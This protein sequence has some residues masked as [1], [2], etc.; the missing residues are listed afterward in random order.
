MILLTADK[1]KKKQILF[2]IKSASE[3][4]KPGLAHIMC[5]SQLTLFV[6]LSMR[7]VLL[8]SKEP[9]KFE[10]CKF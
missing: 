1:V 8:F 5:K 4:L 2:C 6:P 9:R 3:L 7:K 10:I